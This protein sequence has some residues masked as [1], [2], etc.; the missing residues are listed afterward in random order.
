MCCAQFEVRVSTVHTFE[1]SS[2]NRDIRGKPRS[3]QE[4]PVSDKTVVF[5]GVCLKCLGP[6]RSVDFPDFPGKNGRVGQYGRVWQH[7]IRLTTTGTSA[8]K[9]H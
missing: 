8:E 3:F 4:N 7:R 1:K 6:G 2:K 9:P 5:P